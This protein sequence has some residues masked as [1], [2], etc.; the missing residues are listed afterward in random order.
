MPETHM[1]RQQK[2][3][4]IEDGFVVIEN[5]INQDVLGYA[6]DLLL[7]QPLIK[8]RELLV[9]PELTTHPSILAL[10]NDSVL[11]DIIRNE[12][13]P[14][15]EVISCQIAVTPPFDTLG[16]EP[17]PH[18][19]GSWSGRIPDSMSEIDPITTRPKNAAKY[20]GV[21][22]EVRGTNDGQLWLDLER[23]LSIGSYTALVGVALNDQLLPGNGQLA[24]MRG[25]HEAVEEAFIKQRDSH[26]VI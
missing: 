4:F 7:E 10:F 16:G 26:G 11:A 3:Q 22:D 20:F 25:C 6:R 5:A 13:G 24:V 19:D 23:R 1:S 12:M 21:N 17:G 9:T 8:D 15:P 18:V 14:Y 2:S